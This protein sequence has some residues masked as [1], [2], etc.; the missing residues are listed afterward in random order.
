LQRQK[1]YIIVYYIIRRLL[2]TR[3]FL[4]LLFRRCHAGWTGARCDQCQ[5]YPGCVNGY[6]QKPWQCL[7]KE[8][9]GGMFCNQ[10]LNYCTNH[11]PCKN[12]GTCFNTGQGLYTCSCAPGYTGPECNVD[13]GLTNRPGM[14]CS[15]GL[16]CLNGGTCKVSVESIFFVP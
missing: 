12:G 7:C 10:D 3:V 16:T 8:G 2:K 6:C 4:S 15:T 13:M 9:W 14:D 1:Q 11:A 5:I